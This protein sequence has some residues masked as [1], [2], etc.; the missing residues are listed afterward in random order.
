MP[1]R[2]EKKQLFLSNTENETDLIRKTWPDNELEHGQIIEYEDVEKLLNLTRKESR[3]RTITNRWRKLV[4]ENT[5]RTI[6]GTKANVG[7][8]VMSDTD[9]LSLSQ[10]KLKSS[11]RSAKRSFAVSG[12]VNANNLTE[13]ERAQLETAQKRS[14][15]LIAT[16]QIRNR[17]DMPKLG[18]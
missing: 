14:A 13:E 18:E 5:G 11:V 8:L 1:E 6:I 3:F 15:A 9:K 10:R 16:A 4:E 17:V 7:F 2:L 12:A